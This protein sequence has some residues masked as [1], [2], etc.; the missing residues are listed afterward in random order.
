MKSV[1]GHEKARNFGPAA[2]EILESHQRTDRF[3]EP[4]AEWREEGFE[5]GT[6]MRRIFCGAIA[7]ATLLTI[8]LTLSRG[9]VAAQPALADRLFGVGFVPPDSFEL[10]AIDPVTGG[11]TT[12]STLSGVTAVGRS[13]FDSASQRYFL[14]VLDSSFADRLLVID[15]QTGTVLANP[16]LPPG[17]GLGTLQFEP[18]TGRLLG[19][20]FIA[21]TPTGANWLVAINPLTGQ[22]APVGALSGVPVGNSALDAA[23]RRYFLPI[24]DSPFTSRLLVVNTQTGAVLGSPLLSTI[25]SSLEFDPAS[26]RLL[27]VAFISGSPTLVTIDPVTGQLTPVATL[28]VLGPTSPPVSALDAVTHRFFLSAFDSSLSKRLLVVNTQTGT[29]LANPSLSKELLSLEFGPPAFL[30]FPLKGTSP[31]VDEQLDADSAPITSVF[32]HSMKNQNGDYLLYGGCGADINNCDKIVTAYSLEEGRREFGRIEDCYAQ[33]GLLDFFIS[34]FYV[35]PGGIGTQY[36]C[37]D[38]HPGF[39]YRASLRT[40][41]YAAV[42]GAV[43]YPHSMVGI[44]PGEAYDRFH[45]LELIPDGAPGYRIYYLHLATHPTGESATKDDSEGCPNPRVT[46]PLPEGSRV[47]A[48]CLIGLSG[49]AGVPGAPHLHFEVQSVVPREQVPLRIWDIVQCRDTED[50]PVLGKGCIPV[51]PYGWAGGLAQSDPY[52]PLTSVINLRLWR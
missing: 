19:D 29:V 14:Q 35:G 9:Q 5:E 30:N 3:G 25:P 16:L 18:T 46:L 48:G 7:L 39:D 47:Q 11:M 8:E 36:L 38:N 21:A 24:L 28:P 50:P 26:G 45:V 51:D 31:G 22:V 34:G 12:L 32:D 43:H 52:T 6:K 44:R 41:V 13:A 15:T 10:V 2:D 17:Q 40:E 37:Y 23:T 27:G 33:D 20:M 4:M 1:G 42:D 49:D